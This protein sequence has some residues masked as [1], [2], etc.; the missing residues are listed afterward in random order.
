MAA[1]PPSPVHRLPLTAWRD[2]GKLMLAALP[3]LFLWWVLINQLRVEWTVN[4]QYSY[5]WSVPVLCLYLAWRR[6]LRTTGLPDR[7]AAEGNQWAVDGWRGPEP[8]DKG[9]L[10][11]GLRNAAD[12]Q[13]LE[14]ELARRD[15]LS[16]N[17]TVICQ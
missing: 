14:I 8:K 13:G 11:C 16:V 2:R 4:P 3:F 10:S 7:G 12:Y 5:G 15:N 9:S 17:A 1:Y 6:G